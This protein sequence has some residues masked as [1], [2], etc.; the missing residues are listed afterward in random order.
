MIDDF[1][2]TIQASSAA[3][4]RRSAHLA[5]KGRWYSPKS[6]EELASRPEKTTLTLRRRDVERVVGESEDGF[7][8]NLF[9]TGTRRTVMSSVFV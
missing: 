1:D 3:G 2:G 5:R 9:A 4:V 8:G 7:F 6:G